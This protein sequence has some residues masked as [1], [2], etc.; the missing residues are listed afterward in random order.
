MD[1]NLD[2]N[3]RSGP[4]LGEHN[5]HVLREVLGYDDDRIVEL[6]VVAIG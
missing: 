3:T 6:A 5:D 2:S 1:L 4:G